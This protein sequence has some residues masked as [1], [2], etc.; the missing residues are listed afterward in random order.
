MNFVLS[1]LFLQ[2]ACTPIAPAQSL[3]TFTATGDMTVP[4]GGH[5]ATLLLNGKVLIT[6]GRSSSRLNE[7]VA[8]A[9]LY[10]PS[11]GTFTTTGN[12]ITPRQGHTATLLADGKVL[13]TGGGFSVGNAEL[14]DPD[15][16]TF[17]PTGD[18]GEVISGGATSRAVLL[19]NGEVL[20]AGG[21]FARVFD[22]TSGTFSSTRPYTHSGSVYV[23]TATS[24]AEGSVLLTGCVAGAFGCTDGVTQLYDPGSG[25]FSGTGPMQGWWNVN[26]A[27]LLMK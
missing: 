25:T 16:G 21:S 27:T 10:D 11:M 8:A 18:S 1:F 5:T 7:P 22:P 14:Y 19:A 26:T 12:M 2:T 4:R 13:I 17:V 23:S 6:G 15:S 9:E 24:L 20:L 3:G